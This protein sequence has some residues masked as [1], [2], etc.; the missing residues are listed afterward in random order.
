MVKVGL[1]TNIGPWP[2]PFF[3][4]QS[5]YC[6]IFI[7]IVALIISGFV[8][9]VWPLLYRDIKITSGAYVGHTGRIV[10]VGF[11]NLRLRVNLFNNGLSG[12]LINVFLWQGRLKS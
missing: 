2:P 12:K 4:L 5:M 3:Y 9:L 6:L 1:H 8:P 10:K 11:C 7:P